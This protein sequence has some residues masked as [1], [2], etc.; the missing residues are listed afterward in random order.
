MT[1]YINVDVGMT[2]TTESP[3]ISIIMN[4]YNCDRFLKEAIDSVYAQTFSDWEIIFWDNASTDNSSKIANSYDQRL[5]YFCAEVTT[6]LG[7]A[8]NLALKKINGK[9]IGFLDC[10][11]I[12]L[13]D[14]LEK[15]YKLMEES[16]Y[17][18]CYGGTLV[19]DEYGKKIR[20]EPVNY[21]SGYIFNLLLNRYEINMPSVMVRRSVL[22]DNDLSFSSNLQYC[23]DHNLFM[24]IASRFTVGVIRDYI[25]KYRVLSDSLSRKTLHLVSS[26]IQFT[27]DKIID[28]NPEIKKN[29][30]GEVR[31]AYAKLKY[32]D[33]IN[34]ISKNM[35]LDARKALK[36]V[37][38]ER[39]QYMLL[40]L[41]LYLPLTPDKVLS[42]LKR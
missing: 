25:V 8:R 16:D 26:E 37:L 24:E 30:P 35:F 17:A 27:L 14:K 20:K 7:E 12:Y 23:P 19:I 9:Y 13:K 42:F 11:D 5:K 28:R 4:C 39:W 32:Y 41:L 10:D 6:P 31:A 2:M 38:K 33:A 3:M 36:P 22:E 40:Y 15:Q 1:F 18:M 29:Y 34:Y 21:T